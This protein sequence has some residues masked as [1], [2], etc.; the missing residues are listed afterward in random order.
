MSPAPAGPPHCGRPPTNYSHTCPRPELRK[1]LDG[2]GLQD[3]QGFLFKEMMTWVQ[4]PDPE[5]KATL[6]RRCCQKLEEMIQQLQ[7]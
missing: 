2:L 1:L 7:V 4:G 3:P 5:S 6:R